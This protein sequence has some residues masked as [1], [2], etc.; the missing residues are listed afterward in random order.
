MVLD[1][2]CEWGGGGEA[3]PAHGACEAAPKLT[4]G[5]PQNR[6]PL[7]PHLCRQAELRVGRCVAVDARLGQVGREGALRLLLCV[8]AQWQHTCASQQPS[9]STS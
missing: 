5:E 4:S 8:H 7:T 6:P 2:A 1:V 9:Q 3:S